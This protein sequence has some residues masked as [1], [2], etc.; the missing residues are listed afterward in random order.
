MTTRLLLL[1]DAHVNPRSPTDRRRQPV[2]TMMTVIVDGSH[3]DAT[4]VPVR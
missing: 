1:A 2:C 3:L 4:L